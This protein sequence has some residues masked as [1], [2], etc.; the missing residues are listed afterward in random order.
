[1][2]DEVRSAFE[3]FV[4]EYSTNL[5][6]TSYLL[7]GDRAAAEDLLQDTFTRLYPRWSRVMAADAPLAYVR[8]SLTNEFLMAK[9]RRT[10]PLVDVDIS[11]DRGWVTD[12]QDEIGARDA[13]LRLLRNLGE[14][15]RAAVVLRY[16]LAL[17]DQEI[18]HLLACREAT[19]RS[20]VSRGLAALRAAEALVR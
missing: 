9:R 1:M 17:D 15:Q 3:A 7:T 12:A 4:R 5:L 18:G 13:T 19:V 14:R 10:L 2:A 16:Y 6:R 20:L 8:R 11:A